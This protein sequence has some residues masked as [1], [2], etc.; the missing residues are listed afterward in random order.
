MVNK[1]AMV[2]FKK[3]MQETLLLNGKSWRLKIA[4]VE[5]KLER[6]CYIDHGKLRKRLYL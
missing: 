4:M 6:K 1:F 3:H 2:Q 5:G